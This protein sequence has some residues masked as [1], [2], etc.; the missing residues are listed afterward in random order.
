MDV[1]TQNMTCGVLT[2][3]THCKAIEVLVKGYN[4]AQLVQIR[5]TVKSDQDLMT[6]Y[7]LLCTSSVMTAQDCCQVFGIQKLLQPKHSYMI[8]EKN[9]KIIF[10]SPSDGHIWN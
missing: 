1:G 4:S 5:P 6:I 2:N 10:P 3:T 8:C 7:I 9:S